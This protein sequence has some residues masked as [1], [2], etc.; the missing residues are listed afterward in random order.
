[1]LWWI[2]CPIQNSRLKSG[3]FEEALKKRIRRVTAG[4]FTG[5][6]LTRAMDMPTS[7]SNENKCWEVRW[8]VCLGHEGASDLALYEVI[9]PKFHDTSLLERFAES[10]SGEIDNTVGRLTRQCDESLRNVRSSVLPSSTL[11]REMEQ[12]NWDDISEA[13]SFRLSQ[14]IKDQ[15]TAQAEKRRGMLASGQGTM[16]GLE[17]GLLPWYNLDDKS[18]QIELYILSNDG[19]FES[20]GVPTAIDL[21]STVISDF[22]S[23]RRS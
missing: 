1:M 20:A 19:Y 7:A 22:E 17:A 21:R 9:S 4:D 12:Y 15:L 11:G 18:L 5:S 6:D 10:E 2:S 8:E 14:H 3:A 13:A 23:F 16:G